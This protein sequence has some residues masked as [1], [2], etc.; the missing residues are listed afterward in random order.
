MDAKPA[1]SGFSAIQAGYTESVQKTFPLL[2]SMR[3]YNNMTSKVSPS[4]GDL[5]KKKD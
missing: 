5:L 2:Y 1:G 3:G 4:T